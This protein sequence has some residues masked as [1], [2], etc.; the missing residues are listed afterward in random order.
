M[1]RDLK[2][3]NIISKSK[4]NFTKLC[5]VDFG[6]ATFVNKKKQL[7]TR[8]GTPGFVAPEIINLQDNEW[9]NEKCDVFSLGVIFYF[10]LNGKPPF[11][12][13]NKKEIIDLNT[14]C[15]INFNE[16][17]FCLYSKSCMNLL[18]QM[19]MKYPEMRPSVQK[20]LKHKFF[21]DVALQD[22][23]SQSAIQ[24][25]VIS[26]Q[27]KGDYEHRSALLKPEMLKKS[28][29]LKYSK[30]KKR[31]KKIKIAKQK[32]YEKRSVKNPKKYE[33]IYTAGLKKNGSF[34]YDFQ[35]QKSKKEKKRNKSKKRKSK[36][37]VSKKKDDG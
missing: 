28:M 23:K 22:I 14:A 12:C 37:S 5:I 16:H 8:C 24:N 9:Y 6:L 32:H 15:D 19:L 3:E 34:G 29:P 27:S 25:E 36:K 7:F 17:R 13:E 26:H 35:K 1:H 20:C 33:G 30:E 10:L 11:Y 4:Q 18:R 31:P 2:P 21:N